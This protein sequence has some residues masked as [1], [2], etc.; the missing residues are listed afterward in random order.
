[1]RI[2]VVD[3]SEAVRVRIATLLRDIEGVELVAE[4]EDAAGAVDISRSLQPDFVI[5]DLNLPGPSGLEVLPLLKQRSAA[6]TIVVLTN[7][8]GEAYARRCR[9]LGADYFFDKSKQ[10]ETA[11]DV[12]RSGVSARRQR[13]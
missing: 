6:S 5:L 3:D 7:H 13:T 1:M 2:L 9:D 4:A 11:I 12:V 10:F 8:A